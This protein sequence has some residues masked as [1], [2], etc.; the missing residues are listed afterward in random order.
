M[1]ALRQ[2]EQRDDRRGFVVFRVTVEDGVHALVVFGR[3][4]KR[5]IDCVVISITVL[6]DMHF[7]VR[8]S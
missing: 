6:T 1:L 2:V 5:R 4:V 7:I 8:I 3:E